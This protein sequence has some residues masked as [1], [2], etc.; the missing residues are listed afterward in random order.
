MT[1]YYNEIDNSAANCLEQLIAENII[2]DGV[3]DRRSIID[4]QTNDVQGFTQCHWFA[5]IGGWPYALRLA[6]W[7]DDRAVWTGSCPCQPFST[8][9]LQTGFSDER[10]LWPAWY[11]IIC[12]CTPATIFGEQVAGAPFWVDRLYNNLENKNFAVGSAY[13]PAASVGAKHNRPRFFFVANSQWHQQPRQE[14]RSGPAG[15]MGRQQQ[16]ISWDEPWQGA[17][18]RFRVL[19]DGLRRSVGATDA[20]RNAVVPQ[21]AA[22]FI[23]AAMAALGGFKT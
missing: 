9:G 10:D 11:K 7:P 21:V 5:G 16:S 8:A 3:V 14:P 22:E 15:R 13:L 4:V 19:G 18:S 2:P 20:A 12:E 17:L 1:A 23:S 6:G